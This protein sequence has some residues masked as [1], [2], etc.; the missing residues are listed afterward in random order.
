MSMIPPRRPSP[1]PSPRGIG[2][3]ILFVLLLASGCSD[4]ITDPD[5]PVLEESAAWQF[6]PSEENVALRWNR[7][8][9]AAVRSGTLGPPMA[10]RALAIVH[11]AMYDAWAAYDEVATG[12]RLG[13]SLRRPALEHTLEN[14]NSAVSY[15]AYRALLDLYPADRGLLDM[16]MDELGYDPADESSD[17]AT[18]AGVG[19]VAAAAL[20]EFRRSDGSNQ[21]AG[22][23]DWTAYAPVNS[24]NELRDVNRWQPLRLPTTSGDHVLQTFLAPHWGWVTPFA[25]E[26]GSQLRPPAPPSYPDG[27]YRAQVEEVLRMSAQLTDEEKVIVEYWADGPDSEMPPGHWNVLAHF[28]SARDAHGL[29]EDVR[30]FFAL[31]N[32]AMDAGIAAW[33]AKRYYDYVRPI[34]AV[35]HLKADRRI[36]AWAGPGQGTGFINGED[37]MPYQPVT[38]V[39]P[40]FSEYV[41]G[42]STF[43]AA[44]AEILKSF[45]GSDAFGHSVTIRAGSSVVEP[46]VVPSRDVVLRWATFTDAADEAGISRRYG[47]IHF[48]DADIEGR[49]MGRAIGRLVWSRAVGYFNGTGVAVAERE[50]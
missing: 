18:P 21:E 49:A 47:G 6:L 23:A 20:L 1:A 26:S 36:R 12:T 37:W 2:G 46:G 41:S 40:P 45:T 48:R 19:N 16:L 10:A 34:S 29:D 50:N 38:F 4:G 28:V 25:L 15:A 35:R 11:T 31:N 13:G 30:L 42:H 22:Y 43:S 8:A 33:E 27:R 5:A 24:W 17:P 44:S 39:T 14:K 32:A 3:L 9:L 7:A